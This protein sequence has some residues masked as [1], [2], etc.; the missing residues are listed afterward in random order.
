[1]SQVLERLQILLHADTARYQRDIKKASSDTQREFES[2]KTSAQSMAGYVKSALAGFGATAAVSSVIRTADEMRTMTNVVRLNTQSHQ[3][4]KDV[5]LQLKTISNDNLTSIGSTI[6]LYGSSKSALDELGKSQQDVLLFTENIT[7]A[8]AVGGGSAASQQAA[9]VQLAQALNMGA[10]KGQEFNSVASQAP[11][12]L[13]LLKSE[14]GATTAELKDMAAKGKITAEVI[15]SAVAGASTELD[16]KLAQMPITVS[17]AMN[18]VKNNYKSIVNE[19]M[20]EN[21]AL[22]TTLAESVKWVGE[23]LASLSIA[24]GAVGVVW[25]GLLIKNS[26]LVTGFTTFVGAQVAATKAAAVNAFTVQGQAQAYNTLQTRL[27]LLRLTKAHYIDLTKQSVVAVRS[28]TAALLAQARAMSVATAAQRAAAGAAILTA[29]AVSK[30]GGGMMALGRIIKVHPLMTLAAVLSAVVV[31]THGMT[32]ALES[33]SDAFGVTTLMAKDFIVFV[34]DGFSMAWDAVSAFA[35]NMLAKVGDTTKGSTGA[36]SNFFATS[37]GGFVGMLQVAAKTFDLI[38]AAAKAGAQNALHNFVQLGKATQNIFI[39]IGNAFVSTIEFMINDMTRKIDWLSE[40]ANAVAAFLGMESRLPLIGKVNLGRAQY[41]A[42]DFGVVASIA[43]SN[44]HS[45]Y[46]YVTALADQTV[47]ARQAAQS[48]SG[49]ASSYDS[50]GDAASKSGKKA[51]D[52]AKDISDAISELSARVAK[53][54]YESHQLLNNSYSDM[55]FEVTH[56]L[57]KFYKATEK[58]KAALKDLAKQE[59][60]FTATKQANDELKSFARTIALMGKESPFDELLYD[61]FDMRNEL[62]VLNKETKDQLLLWAAQTEEVRLITELNQKEADMLHEGIK[63]AEKSAYRRDV[64]DIEREI[65]KELEKYAGLQREGTEHIYKQIKLN[66]ENHATER[67]KLLTQQ[68]YMQLVFDSRTEAEKNLDTLKEQLDVLREQAK[69]LGTMGLD[70]SD[71]TD[72]AKR[73][74]TD[75]L[76]LPKPEVS[77]YQMLDD[78][79]QSRHDILRAGVDQMLQNERL[80]EEERIKIKE[81]GVDERLKIE[82]AY[83][84]AMSSLILSDSENMFGSLASITKD[85]LGEQSRLYR[86]MFAMQ[87]GFAIA[88]AGLDMQQAISKGL[89]KGFPEGLA[90]MAMAVS[91]GAKIVSAIK[92]V[93]MPVGQAHDGIMSVPKSGTWNLE[94][95]ERVLPRH[96]AKALDDKLDKIGTGDRPVNVVINNY[97][98]EKTDVQQMPNGDMMVTIGKMISHTVDAKLN[99]RFIQARRQGGELYG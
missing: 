62:S 14:L 92:S 9:L 71:T 39:G 44:T 46:N 27:M 31:S 65:A 29:N 23:N 15:Y 13:A 33:L 83:S 89:A 50:V 59:D 38:N 88:Q 10:L 91:H 98:G 94:K 34:G 60:M 41:N 52:S 3:E 90:D 99:Q 76:G 84:T 75:A 74:I 37:H 1:M 43:D 61:L 5:L 58:Q 17:G 68:A 81:W 28:N 42:V 72:I 22:T 11:A 2:I 77:A 7:K 55:L 70:Y 53:L 82:K 69:I 25:G 56:E 24:A 86:A 93:V 36:F 49:L 32:G 21:S 19:I 45:A 48:N 30:V 87:Q 35:D 47:A 18:V 54:H 80:T 8:M 4:Y 97:S 16:K 12:I 96:T 40:K 51:S 26:A 20:N 6:E 57:G 95:G 73:I 67:K 85:S 64:L 66:L 79:R 78:E 63:S